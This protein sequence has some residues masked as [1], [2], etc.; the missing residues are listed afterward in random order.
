MPGVF[1]LLEAASAEEAAVVIKSSIPT[2]QGHIDGVVLDYHGEDDIGAVKTAVADAIHRVPPL[3]A[4][5]DVLVKVGD[6]LV[7]AWRFPAKELE[8]TALR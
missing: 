8:N 6:D 7:A 4:P 1:A 5:L 2:G 3:E